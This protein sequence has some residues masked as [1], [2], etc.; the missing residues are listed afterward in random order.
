MS[1]GPLAARLARTARCGARTR[2]GGPCRCP[3]MR[4]GRCRMHGGASTGP[5][6]PEGLERCRRASLKHGL[7]SAAAVAERRHAAAVRRTIRDLI[8]AAGR[9]DARN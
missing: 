6:T 8:A 7:R 4:N 3:A 2:A 1:E 5:R 9:L